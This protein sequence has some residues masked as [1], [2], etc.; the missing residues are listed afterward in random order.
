M[1]PVGPQQMGVLK[2][3]GLKI[4]PATQ[5]DQE[6]IKEGIETM[7]RRSALAVSPGFMPPGMK[8]GG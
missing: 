8:R 7:N 2:L 4:V 6:T 5:E 1:V 3:E